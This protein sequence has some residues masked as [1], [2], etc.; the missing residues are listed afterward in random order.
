MKNYYEVLEVSQNASDEIISR[1]YKVLAK[2]Y[3][4]DMNPDNLE[5]ASEK[6]K[7]VAEAYEVLSNPD[8]KKEYD[9]SLAR[10]KAREAYKQ[11]SN[12]TNSST[13][14]T[15]NYSSNTSYQKTSHYEHSNDIVETNSYEPIID[16]NK[17]NDIL[18]EH[19]NAI[20]QAY[21]DAYVNA[22]KSM[23][24][25]VTYKKTLKERFHS[26]LRFLTFLIVLVVVIFVLLQIPGV[27]TKLDELYN[28]IPILK[29]FVNGIKS[30]FNKG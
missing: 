2:K 12:S 26:F 18:T 9:D 5:E 29:S 6:F 16:V 15:S 23:G 17:I 22:L 8:K 27:K 11:Q 25:E 13:N 30:V 14:N 10:E 3:H 7:E 4:P 19:E 20:G 21:N 24:I 28:S 1:A